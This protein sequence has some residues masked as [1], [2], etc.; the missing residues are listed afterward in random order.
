MP[1]P[2][3]VVIEPPTRAEPGRALCS[4]LVRTS[5]TFVRL[6]GVACGLGS[7]LDGTDDT[8]MSFV[9][10]AKRASTLVGRVVPSTPVIGTLNHA[11]AGE[12]ALQIDSEPPDASVELDAR[13]VGRTPMAVSVASATHRVRL[14][15]DSY[16]EATDTDVPEAGATIVLQAELLRRRPDVRRSPGRVPMLWPAWPIWLRD[17][18]IV[19]LTQ[20]ARDGLLVVPGIDAN[21]LDRRVRVDT[22]ALV[23]ELP[24]QSAK[25][26]TTSSVRWD[27]TSS[28]ALVVAGHSAGLGIFPAAQ[29][30]H[31]LVRIGRF[32]T[33]GGVG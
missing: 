14:G 9:R 22:S 13:I 19:A 18:R 24:I 33:G 23:T 27:A 11:P 20:P 1:L 29:Q 26:A 10:W 32:G 6:I 28:Q 25:S 17:G 5:A 2:F 7:R 15:R 12:A 16:A 31:W 8:R 3:V 4:W 21:R 30:E